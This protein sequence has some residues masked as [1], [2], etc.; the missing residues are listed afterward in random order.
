MPPN[1][2]YKK[3]ILNDDDDDDDDY[4]DYDDE[5]EQF[6]NVNNIIT[7]YSTNKPVK[8]SKLKL[9][10]FPQLTPKGIGI[11]ISSKVPAGSVR[12][13]VFTIIISTVGAGCLSLYDVFIY[14]YL[15]FYSYYPFT[16]HIYMIYDI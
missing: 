5:E 10:S 15:Y 16:Y 7:K 4:D 1:A 13:S 8:P 9:N 6:K 11:Y 14:L 3:L 2:T 12:G